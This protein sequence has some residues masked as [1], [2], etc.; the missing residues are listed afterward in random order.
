MHGMLLYATLQNSL[1]ESRHLMGCVILHVNIAS[2]RTCLEL[3][4]IV[5]ATY[6]VIWALLSFVDCLVSVLFVV[7]VLCVATESQ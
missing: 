6:V 5:K 3:C 4:I 2:L 1:L 7:F